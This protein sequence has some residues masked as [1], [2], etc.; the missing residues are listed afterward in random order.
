M[1]LSEI[2]TKIETDRENLEFMPTGYK[3]LDTWMDGGFLKKEVIVIGGSTG[4][5][6][7]YFSGQLMANI[8]KEGFRTAYFSLEITNEMMASRL[9]GA[10]SNI[11]STVI[12]AD[13]MQPSD[14]QR[15]IKSRAKLEGLENY[16]D[17]YDNVYEF[18]KIAKEIRDHK[19]EFVVV[20][21]IQI[22]VIPGRDEYERMTN[23]ATQFQKLA[24]E[25]GCCIVLLSQLSNEQAVTKLE[26]LN[27]PQFKGSG[28]IAMVADQG[29]YLLRD[30]SLGLQRLDL[31]MLKNRRGPRPSE[32]FTYEFQSPGGLLYEA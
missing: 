20:D 8:A 30:N 2:V 26:S 19:F 27:Y 11:K 32:P 7:S 28:A 29:Y 6:K 17:F 15:Y 16:M 18:E 22:L 25:T 9:I 12:I 23:A 4:V 10:H 5:G 24:K 13:L 31:L 14:K 3:K 1:K 21:F